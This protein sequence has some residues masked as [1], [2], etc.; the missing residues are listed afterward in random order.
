MIKVCG[1]RGRGLFKLFI[2]FQ[3]DRQLL[4]LLEK[5]KHCEWGKFGGRTKEEEILENLR[6]IFCELQNILARIENFM[7]NI[8]V[9]DNANLTKLSSAKLIRV[10]IGKITM[11]QGYIFIF[12]ECKE[13]ESL[14]SHYA[15]T[16]HD[17]QWVSF[18]LL[19]EHIFSATNHKVTCRRGNI[20]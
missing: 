4:Q 13:Q 15:A 12:C 5:K 19:W 10:R 20:F 6:I 7:I 17:L 2:W 16:L 3:A 18:M 14:K 9:G 8:V 11:F 1:K